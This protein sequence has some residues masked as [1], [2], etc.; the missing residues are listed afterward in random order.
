MSSYNK[1]T[2]QQSFSLRDGCRKY[3]CP[4]E[5]VSYKNGD[6]ANWLVSCTAVEGLVYCRV[7]MSYNG[8]KIYS[9]KFCENTNEAILFIESLVDF[10]G[11]ELK[12]LEIDENTSEESI[13]SVVKYWINE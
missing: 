3:I 4:K 9:H 7:D 5:V 2:I 1:N 10:Y 11:V 8:F 12:I 6:K 13:S